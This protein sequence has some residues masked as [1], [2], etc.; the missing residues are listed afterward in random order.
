MNETFPEPKESQI[1]SDGDFCERVDQESDEVTCD[2]ISAAAWDEFKAQSTKYVVFDDD[3]KSNILGLLLRCSSDEEIRAGINDLQKYHPRY[4][5][6]DLKKIKRW[7]V[8]LT[9]GKLKPGRRVNIR[10]ESDVWS[11]LVICAFTI[12]EDEV[13]NSAKTAEESGKAY[14][15]IKSKRRKKSVSGAIPIVEDDFGEKLLFNVTYSYDIIRNQA[16]RVQKESKYLGD[17]GVQRLKFS[18]KW[19]WSFL[20]RRNFS[21]RRVTRD[22]KNLPS[23]DEVNRVMKICQKILV[24]GKYSLAQIINVDE[25]AINWAI[26]PQYIYTAKNSDRGVA[27]HGTD[28]KARFTGVL[29]VAANGD[30]LPP[31]LIIKHS[32]SSSESPDQTSMKV[33]SQLHNKQGFTDQDGWRFETFQ[34]TLQA[35]DGKNVVHKINYLIHTSGAVITSKYKAYNDSIRMAMFIKLI[36]GP[37]AAKVAPTENPTDSK[38]YLWQDNCS[39]HKV[40]WLDNIYTEQGVTVG[41]LP[42]NM[43]WRQQVLDLVVNVPLKAEIRNKRAAQLVDYMQEFRKEFEQNQNAT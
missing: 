7:R 36:L 12:K 10:F 24:D 20:N 17:I 26:Q 30:F 25:T 43:T 31:F 5:K 22:A 23:E 2:K 38:L 27:E 33:I 40:E 16:I 28:L 14:I 11:R 6:L 41:Y 34:I 32:K 15:K 3:E 8:Q 37:Y 18:N 29:G 21:R 19:I 35:D 9:K 42:A 1:D 39:L 13:K 4:L